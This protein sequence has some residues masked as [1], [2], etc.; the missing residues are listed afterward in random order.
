MTT[1]L[2]DPEAPRSDAADPAAS[3]ADPTTPTKVA[4]RSAWLV[5]A[6][7]GVANLAVRLP[8]LS[9]PGV[10]VF[11]EIFYAPDANDLL[12]FGIEQGQVKHPPLGKWLIAGGIRLFG[13]TPFGWRIASVVA[14]ALAATIIASAAIRLTKRW[15]LGVLAGVLVGLD[16]IM[17]TTS[18]VA[19]LDIFVGLF[20]S[21]AAWFAVAAWEAQPDLSRVRR[22]GTGALLCIGLSAGV[23]WSAVFTLPVVLGEMLVLEHRLAA[24]GRPR[25]KGYGRAVGLAAVLP[26]VVYVAAFL[27]TFAT[28]SDALPPRKFVQN[29]EDILGF[30]E[31]LKPRNPYAVPAYNWL[32][33]TRPAA[34]YRQLCSPRQ[35]PTSRT[36]PTVD[37]PTEIRVLAVANPVGWWA[38]LVAGVALLGLVAWAARWRALLLLLLGLSQWVP[39]LLIS[40]PPYSFYETGL[41]P[42]MALWVPAVLVELPRRWGAVLAGLLGVAVVAM[43]VFLYPLWAALPLSPVAAHG[44]MLRSWP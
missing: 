38:G 32:L 18:R 26:A 1:A 12:R 27:P 36:C 3:T 35:G 15:E 19:M 33:Q 21:A 2:A 14:G 34:L 9:K 6:A 31:G 40:R 7:V 4:R 30:H 29:Q 44:R 11:D 42:L 5:P 39:W 28:R 25:W 10:L 13:F 41:I 20:L 43:F 23:K 17:F 37:H 16:G 24:P 22:Y 8:R